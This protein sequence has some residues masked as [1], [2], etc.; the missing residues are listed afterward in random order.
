MRCSKCQNIW[1]EWIISFQNWNGTD[2][3]AKFESERLKTFSLSFLW[4]YFFSLFLFSS[5]FSTSPLSLFLSLSSCHSLFLFSSYFTTS[6][7]L[8]LSHSSF[9]SDCLSLSSFLLFLFFL[10]LLFLISYDR[11]DDPRPVTHN[12]DPPQR[13]PSSLFLLIPISILLDDLGF[14]FFFLRFF[15]LKF[16]GG[17]QRLWLWVCGGGCCEFVMGV[18]LNLIRFMVVVSVGLW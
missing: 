4:L 11:E 15:D 12:G 3:N 10:F 7:F 6:L 2:I 5:F 14:F 18:W 17:F 1:H 8:S 9:F 13:Q 16:V